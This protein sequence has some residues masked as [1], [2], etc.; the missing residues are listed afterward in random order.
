LIQIKD[1]S[2]CGLCCWLMTRWLARFGR[3][4]GLFRRVPEQGRDHIQSECLVDG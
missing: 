4:A 3:A 2:G 1:W